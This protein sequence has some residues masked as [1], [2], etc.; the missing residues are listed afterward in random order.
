FFLIVTISHLEGQNLSTHYSEVQRGARFEFGKNWRRFLSVLDEAR[1]EQAIQS[2]KQNLAIE[3]LRGKRFLDIGSGSGLFSLAARRLGARVL[4]FDYY[5]GSVACTMELRRRY[6]PNDGEWTIEEA[7]ALDADYLRTLGQFDVVYS[8]GVL[9]HTGAM[10]QGLDLAT[11]PVAEGGKLFIAIYNNQGR[12]TSYW[13]AI[14]ALYNHH[15]SLRPLLIITHAP[16]LFGLRFAIRALTGRLRLERGMSLWYDML[17]WLGGYPFETAT[18][19]EIAR[20]YEGR[21][22][23]LL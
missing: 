23:H 6:F 8:W 7:S 19:S 22:F 4:S 21:L 15:A 11:L 16:Y 18:P 12:N 2:L 10:W 14:K 9:H 1:I 20:F 17:D 3:D 5:P 13:I